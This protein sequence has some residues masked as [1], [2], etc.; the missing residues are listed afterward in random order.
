[1]TGITALNEGF[2]ISTRPECIRHRRDSM[3]PE[4][5]DIIPAG[6]AEAMQSGLP[7]RD[8]AEA[9]LNHLVAQAVHG[10]QRAI[11][12]LLATVRAMV[13]PYCRARL[14]RQQSVIGSAEDVV[15]DVCLGVLTA[16]DRYQLRGLSFRAFV[17]GIA[18][19]KVIDSFRASVR[20]RSDLMAE[21]DDTVVNHD[22]P[23]Q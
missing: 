13:L 16:L 15:Q 9:T 21:V 19:H 1:M 18:A 4:A 23:E 11:H 3:S 14:G 8:E 7:C 6:S 22:D 12:E 17:Y 20:D 2:D 10:D 5:S